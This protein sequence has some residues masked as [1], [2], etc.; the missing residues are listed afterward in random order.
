M[1]SKNLSE[2]TLKI[3][4][5]LRAGCTDWVYKYDEDAYMRNCEE[6]QNGRTYKYEEWCGYNPGNGNSCKSD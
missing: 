4:T 5:G 6:D 3:R 2:I 1:E